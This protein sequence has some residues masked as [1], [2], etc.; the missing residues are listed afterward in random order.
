MH[1]RLD[2]ITMTMFMYNVSA[3]D[4]NIPALLNQMENSFK[5][6]Y[7]SIILEVLVS[8]FPVLINLPSPM[9]K[10]TVLV[11]AELL[12]MAEDMWSG[13]ESVGMHA[14]V[15]DSLSAFLPFFKLCGS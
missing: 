10:W 2:A 4:S 5:I 8:M 15:L 3:S 14:K 7:L 9:K 12:V 11:R 1:R 6:G 13:K